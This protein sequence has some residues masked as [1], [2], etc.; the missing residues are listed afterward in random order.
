MASGDAADRISTA[1]RKALDASGFP[2]QHAIVRYCEEL[3][4]SGR[5]RWTV[6]VSEFPV[7][8]QEK[9]THID[10][11]LHGYHSESGRHAFLVCEC[12]RPNP[13]LNW[14]FVRAQRVFR[15]RNQGLVIFESTWIEPTTGRV[16]TSPIG[17]AERVDPYNIA[18]EIKTGEPGNAKGESRGAIESAATQVLRG[19]N[20][21][22]DVMKDHPRLLHDRTPAIVVPVIFTTAQVYTSEDDIAGTADRATGTLPA[23][24]SGTESR[25]LW[26]Q[27]NLSTALRH[28]A[29][30][31]TPVAK[32]TKLGTWLAFQSSRSI[33]IVSPTG[34]ETFLE[35]MP[36]NLEDLEALKVDVAK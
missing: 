10:F 1:F 32:V 21:L 35:E 18:V 28:T 20:G 16:I 30:K 22:I 6:E 11:V 23:N 25:W 2:F 27:Y 19:L 15:H 24:F 7:D 33:A 13:A 26:F 17:L 31:D 8:V 4:S 36:S 29:P 12:K 34:V 3:R 14:G 9:N 5:S